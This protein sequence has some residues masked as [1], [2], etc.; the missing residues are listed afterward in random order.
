MLSEFPVATAIASNTS[1]ALMA[2]RLRAYGYG[3]GP[4]R[5]EIWAME[6]LRE[7][8]GTAVWAFQIGDTDFEA[9]GHPMLNE[10]I[11]RF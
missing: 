10:A 11:T 7:A 4:R 9:Q 3:S 6:L 2:S 8:V 5:G 1:P